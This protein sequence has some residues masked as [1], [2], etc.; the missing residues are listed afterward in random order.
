MDSAIA[1]NSE[2]CKTCGLCGKVCPNRIMKKDASKVMV[3]RADRIQL[4]F[5]C[6]QCMAIC[7]T[8]SISIE[9]LSYAKDFGELPHAAS[10]EDALADLMATRRAVRTFRK[11]PVPRALLEKVAKAIAYAPP[12]FPPIKTEI[13]VVKDPEVIRQALPHMIGVYDFLV[14]SI[15]DPGLRP[16]IRASAGEEKF[17]TVVNHVVPLM[18]IRLPDLK[19]GVEDTITRNAPAMIVFH[20]DKEAENHKEDIY[21]ALAFGL[22]AAHSLGLG[23][24][25]IDL[26]PPAIERS[27]ELRRMFSIPDGNE[28][29]ASM[30][31]GFPKHRYQRT[32]RRELK[33]VE[34]I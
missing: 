3:L 1:I 15:D 28:V 16:L 27:Q 11:K 8:Q 7:P 32:I 9:G 21:I 6:G 20:A 17:R 23:A 34:W 10:Y 14:N 2:T 19:A 24:C 30:I 5:K 26:I 33:S 13:V 22:L 31:L 25:A 12:S 18:K 29:V 4:C